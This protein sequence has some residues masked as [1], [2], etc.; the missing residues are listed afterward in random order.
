MNK[1]MREDAVDKTALRS[2]EI[3]IKTHGENVMLRDQAK[4]DKS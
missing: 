1:R 2:K 3:T 4:Y